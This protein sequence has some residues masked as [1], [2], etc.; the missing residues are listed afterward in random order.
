MVAPDPYSFRGMMLLP[1]LAAA[2]DGTEA[3][4]VGAHLLER[5]R[6]SL[7]HRLPSASDYEL[8]SLLRALP[9]IRGANEWAKANDVALRR[10]VA[11]AVERSGDSDDEFRKALATLGVS[12]KEA[13]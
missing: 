8:L 12:L 6:I 3:E 2:A 10:A 7:G 4:W 1:N 9:K 5:C 11:G 13:P